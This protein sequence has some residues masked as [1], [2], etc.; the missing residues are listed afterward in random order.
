MAKYKEVES[1][2]KKRDKKLKRLMKD[3][4]HLLHLPAKTLSKEDKSPFGG[5]LR[6]FTKVYKRDK[7]GNKLKEKSKVRCKNPAIKGSFFC[8]KHGGGNKFNLVHG[9]RTLANTT[10][11]LYGR[12]MSAKLGDLMDQFLN[13]PKILDLTPE[14]A[15]LRLALSQ[16]ME[17]LTSGKTRLHPKDL[18]RRIKD[19]SKDKS[20]SSK[21]RFIIIRDICASQ[22]FLTDGDSLDRLHKIVETISRVAERM[23]RIQTQDNYLLTPEGL[24]IF[25]RAIVDLLKDKIVDKDIMDEIRNGL[26]D[27]STQTKGNLHEMKKNQGRIDDA[28][29]KFV[30]E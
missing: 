15:A 16:Y 27:I 11:G 18:I 3:F 26:L 7:S 30:E 8:K 4:G 5:G 23:H 21:E 12:G 29:F 2:S 24:K 19:I 10:G 20:I 28:D 9:K 25:L 22:S 14:L 17:E 13:D 6:C 1:K